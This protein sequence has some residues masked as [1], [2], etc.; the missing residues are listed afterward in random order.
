MAIDITTKAKDVYEWRVTYHDGRQV[1]EFD[2]ERPDGRGFLEI[3]SS[4]VKRLRLLLS[5]GI[6]AHV[7]TIPDGATPVF[8]RRRTISINPNNDTTA[9]RP[10]KHCIG[11][12]KDEQAVYLF[13]FSDGSTLLTTDKQ[14]V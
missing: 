3:D 10:V 9:K 11:W 1:P 5:S 2:E 6:P 7:V 4:Q 12:K 8:F 14:A 13:V